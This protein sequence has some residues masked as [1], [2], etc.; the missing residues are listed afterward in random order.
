MSYRDVA[1]E[2]INDLEAV[3]DFYADIA[4]ARPMTSQMR[5]RLVA[6]MIS[7]PRRLRRLLDNA[8]KQGGAEREPA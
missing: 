8:D 2:A 4:A 5:I 7:E 1:I 6:L 3:C